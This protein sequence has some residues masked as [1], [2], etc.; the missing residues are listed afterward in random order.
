MDYN[1]EHWYA[2][3]VKYRTE[4]FI[5]KFLEEKEI[6]HFIPFRTVF[7]ECRGKRIQRE[8][9]VISCLIFVNTD[10]ATAISIP[11][12]SG[13][14]V[15]YIYN[16]DTKRFQIIPD[17][18]MQDFMFLVDYS[19]SI[20]RIPNYKLKKGD[21]VRVIKGDFIGIEGELIRVKGHKRVVVRLEGI[22]SVA[23]TYIP[24]EYLEKI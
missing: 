14:I 12:E 24:G 13:F 15:S 9:P 18:Q 6:K 4:K 16:N 11:N 5:K 20:M 21:R 10:Y 23:T 19:E 3:R 2:A 7:R 1:I 8:K 22:F 17:K